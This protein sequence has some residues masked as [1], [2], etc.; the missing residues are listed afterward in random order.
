[1]TFEIVDIAAE[2]R[3]DIVAEVQTAMATSWKLPELGASPVIES[4]ALLDGVRAQCRRPWT[5]YL[6]ELRNR[7]VRE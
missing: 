3:L 7:R 6:P 2:Q 5:E 4:V 1:K